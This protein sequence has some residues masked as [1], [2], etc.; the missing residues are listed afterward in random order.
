MSYKIALTEKNNE[1]LITFEN[2]PTYKIRR[3]SIALLMRIGIDTDLTSSDEFK[4][5][6][7]KARETGGLKKEDGFTIPL[8][9]I[10]KQ[11]AAI[12]Q[13][14]YYGV[15]APQLTLETVKGLEIVNEIERDEKQILADEICKLSGLN[16]SAVKVLVPFLETKEPLQR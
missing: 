11:Y 3:L 12:D 9:V 7:K 5:L 8:D 1:R 13:I 15:V 14:V 6:M 2:G 10:P 4:S 16:S